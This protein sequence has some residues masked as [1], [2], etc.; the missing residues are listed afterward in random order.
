MLLPV[1]LI[2]TAFLDK[3]IRRE[4]ESRRQLILTRST[5]PSSVSRPWETW[6]LDK[7]F[8]RALSQWTLDHPETTLDRVLENISMGIENAKDIFSVIPDSPFPAR[9]LV[10]ALAHLFKLGVI[11]SSAKREV[12]QFAKDV[13]HWVGK[14]KVAFESAK[15]GRFTRS[16]WRDL[17]SVRDLIEEICQWAV[18]RLEDRRWLRIGHGLTIH[19][20]ITEF[21]A[22]IV[23]ARAL[24]Q[25]LAAVNLARGMDSIKRDLRTLLYRQHVVI[26]EIKKIK[27]TQEH[28]LARIIDEMEKQKQAA[29]R[30]RFFSE[31]L[32]TRTVISP[33]YDKQDKRPCDPDTR[34]EVLADIKGWVND[35]RLGSPNFLWLTGD[36]GCGKSAIT[37]SITRE[38][39]NQHVLWAQF[40]INRNNAETTDPNSYFPSIARQLANR[41]EDV[42]QVIH[43]ILKNELSLMDGISAEQAAKLFVDSIRMAS[44]LEPDR[45]VVVV[46]DGLDETDRRRLKDTATI[47][48]TL[49]PALSAHANVKVFISSRTEDE[50]RNPFAKPLHSKHVKRIHLDTSNPTSLRDVSA[51]VQRSLMKIVEER[52]LNWDVWPGELRANALGLRASGLFIWAVTAIKFVQEQIDSHGVECLHDVLDMLTADNLDDINTLY[53]LILRITLKDNA[54]EWEFERFRRIIGAIIFLQEPLSLDDLAELLDLRKEWSHPVDIPHFVRRLRTVLVTGTDA[55]DGKTIPRLHKSFFE[56]ITSTH[57][58]ARF[59]V[60]PEYAN[61]EL[62]AQCLHQFSVASVAINNSPLPA[63]FRYASRFWFTHLLQTR[64]HAAAVVFMNRK[65][66]EGGLLRGPASVQYATSDKPPLV[67]D[68][69]P[70]KSQVQSTINTLTRLWDVVSGKRLA[71]TTGLSEG[72][73]RPVTCLAFS[74]DGTQVVSCSTDNNIVLWDTAT[75]VCNGTIKHSNSV[76]IVAFSPDGNYIIS[77]SAD[78]TLCLWDARSGLS[79]GSSFEGHSGP[80][81]CIAFSSNGRWFVSGS[82]DKSCRVWDMQV[83]LPIGEPLRCSSGVVSVTVSPEHGFVLL[84]T[85]DGAIRCWKWWSHTLQA[86]LVLKLANANTAKVMMFLPSSNKFVIGDNDGA[87]HVYQWDTEV[88]QLLGP[89]VHAHTSAVLAIAPLTDGEHI[90]SGSSYNICVQEVSNANNDANHEHWSWSKV[91]GTEDPNAN[92]DRLPLAFSPDGKHLARAGLSVSIYEVHMQPSIIFGH[93]ENGEKDVPNGDEFRLEL[94]SEVDAPVYALLRTPS[95]DRAIRASSTGSVNKELADALSKAVVGWTYNGE[96]GN[97]RLEQMQ[98]SS[99]KSQDSTGDNPV[100]WAILDHHIVK[101]DSGKGSVTI[102]ERES[103]DNTK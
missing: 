21:R 84:G 14:V 38:C 80:V 12:Q 10:T 98:W 86:Q 61:L 70:V 30:E 44:L 26:V 41:S 93:N 34:V 33:T 66:P 100:L 75:G 99:A 91:A 32:A 97:G 54:A 103:K 6:E 29:A 76:L 94:C 71:V 39:K 43:D 60:E 87:T 56:F 74:P 48:S 92:L 63:A 46:I 72:H 13:A 101:A 81:T 31:T 11:I 15:G 58:D 25:D 79:V 35:I 7:D 9:G 64:R 83:G 82:T 18:A 36:P 55:V 69:S 50:I 42:A 28:Q 68:V 5:Q 37:A 20:E 17:R 52:D 102:F 19:K 3:L 88:C 57:V 95:P 65:A 59:R 45:P 77:G 49:F 8:F 27:D 89:S 53:G 1:D 2:V 40:F 4:E 47:F 73:T 96:V 62:A 90:L 78:T 23:D 51:F 67:L 22:R 24:F 85:A 16:A